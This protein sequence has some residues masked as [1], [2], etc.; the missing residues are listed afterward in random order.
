MQ[1]DT[2]MHSQPTPSPSR[3]PRK[4]GRPATYTFD[5]P[6][7]ELSEKE[8]KQKIAIEKRRLRQ[9]RSYHR[10]KRNRK[11]ATSTPAVADLPSSST[12]PA[13]SLP[14]WPSSTVHTS[15]ALALPSTLHTPRPVSGFSQNPLDLLATAGGSLGPVPSATPVPVPS[16]SDA[17][18]VASSVSIPTD[19]QT[20]AADHVSVRPITFRDAQMTDIAP[21]SDTLLPEVD[22]TIDLDNTAV[23]LDEAFPFGVGK[24]RDDD[25]Q[26][27]A[28]D[29][30]VNSALVAAKEYARDSIS[31]KD[32]VD[33]ETDLRR[34]TGFKQI[35]FDNL[36]SKYMSLS[37]NVQDALRHL[38]IFPRTFNLRAAVSVAG[39]EESQLIVMQG[40]ID[41]M[42]QANFIITDKGRYE[43]HEAARMFLNEDQ[44]VLNDSISGGTY[45]VA[46][47]RFISHFRTQLS[48]LQDDNIHK[49]GWLRE[50]AM[51][52]YDTERENMEFSE[53][54]LSGRPSELREFLSA[55]I[56]V[57][58]YCVSAGNRERLLRKALMD[59]E[60][61]TENI[62]LSFGEDNTVVEGSASSDDI[63]KVGECDKSHRARL[64]LALSEA[65]FDQLKSEDA[66]KPLL[67]A[68][69]LM[70]DVQPKCS[71]PS[72]N[73][74]YSVLVLL[75]LSNLRLSAKRIKE[76]R[77]LCVKALKILAEAGLGRST[78]GI[79]AMSNLVTIYLEDGHMNKAKSVAN[80]LLDTL[81][82]MR[83]T[84]MPIYADALGV[85]A[86][87]SMA[88][89]NY[90]EAE[91]QYGTAVETVRKWGSKEWTGPPVQHCLDLDLWLM[92]GLAEAIRRQGRVEEAVALEQRAAEARENRGLPR[93]TSIGDFLLGHHDLGLDAGSI[94]ETRSKLRH[95][96]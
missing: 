83:Y 65:Y 43:L 45:E 63:Q 44:T 58:R 89:K 4:P 91:Q 87:V 67:Q 25:E 69:K 33:R 30:L 8:R 79:N 95:L 31:L 49:V 82:T 84:G 75:L 21:S 78:F 52:L 26:D 20:S 73:I 56:T 94:L 23:Q 60:T 13:S 9:N 41:V 47:N 80:R 96:Y 85:C 70:G 12:Q 55:G 53:Y 10:R 2:Q 1:A 38:I 3:A 90:A 48:K 18:A 19:R 46:Q 22:T 88:E 16:T 7:S 27:E 39:L 11:A 24:S 93:N 35:V 54:L 28:T 6:D 72:S 92:E 61:S 71:T 62:F 40:M 34:M 64:Q 37:R 14:T 51:A 59:D 74:V 57:M 77:V 15:A 68:L 36:R 76:A 42:I 32:V 50:Q 5:K 66:E 81:N 17:S 86:M 29:V